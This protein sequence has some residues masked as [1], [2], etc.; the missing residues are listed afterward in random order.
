MRHRRRDIPDVEPAYADAEAARRY[1][2]EALG[3]REGNIIFL[4]D[5]TGAQI[6]RVFGNERDPRGQVARLG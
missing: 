3:V 5:A 6:T 1:A 2:L 4:E